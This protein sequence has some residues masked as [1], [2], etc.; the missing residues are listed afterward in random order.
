MKD[1][2]RVLKNNLKGFL[3][4]TALSLLLVY[5]GIQDYGRVWVGV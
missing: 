3:E 5:K 2:V 1:F 4:G